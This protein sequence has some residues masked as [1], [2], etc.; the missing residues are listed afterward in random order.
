MIPANPGYS[1]NDYRN[2]VSKLLVLQN[3]AGAA[4]SGR[5]DPANLTP[6]AGAVAPS[7]NY[8]APD[9]TLPRQPTPAAAG[10]PPTD[11]ATRSPTELMNAPVTPVGPLPAPVTA[12]LPAATMPASSGFL[13]GDASAAM[14][15]SSG[16]LGGDAPATPNY[17]QP[18]DGA[19]AAGATVGFSGG[20]MAGDQSAGSG[21]GGG[22]GG[23][24]GK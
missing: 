8:P 10:T 3:Q 19:G 11:P 14:P 15:A 21:S 1:P 18:V 16:F 20:S 13:G 22:A 23:G 17:E 5:P 6:M 7:G 2:M 4:M 9:M 24:S 12:P